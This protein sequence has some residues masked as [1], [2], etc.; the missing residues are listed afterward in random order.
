MGSGASVWQNGLGTQLCVDGLLE[1]AGGLAEYVSEGTDGTWHYHQM[2][3]RFWNDAEI[4]GGHRIWI[5]CRWEPEP[6]DPGPHVR[7]R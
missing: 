4:E 7:W 1:D 6:E 2:S 3:Q 5:V